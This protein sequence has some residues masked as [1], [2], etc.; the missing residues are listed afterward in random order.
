MAQL[1]VL[2]GVFEVLRKLAVSF[3]EGKGGL[4]GTANCFGGSI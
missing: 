2:V 4:S 3:L 1:T